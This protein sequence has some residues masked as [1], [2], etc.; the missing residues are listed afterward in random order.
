MDMNKNKNVDVGS[1]GLERIW[2]FNEK[3]KFIYF[4]ALVIFIL[5]SRFFTVN[6]IMFS[7]ANS[8]RY[9]ISALIQSEAAIFAIVITLSL[10]A[11]QQSASSYSPRVIEIFK[12]K[13]RNP[14]F[15]ILILIYVG[16]ILYGA[17][18]LK[19]IEG[20]DFPKSTLP[21]I[22]IQTHIWITYFLAFLA[23]FSLTRYVK[24]AFDLLNPSY[25]IKL[26]SENITRESL[27]SGNGI[28]IDTKKTNFK[29]KILTRIKIFR[30][31]KI[32]RK[33]IIEETIPA[34]TSP[35]LFDKDRDPILPIVDII[36]GS[37]MKYDYETTT[38]GIKTIEYNLINIMNSEPFFAESN[39]QLK[40]HDALEDQSYYDLIIINPMYRNV[41]EHL[42]NI[43]QLAVV[44]IDN[45]SSIEI[46]N[47]ITNII[48][49]I[50]KNKEINKFAQSIIV[51]GIFSLKNIGLTAS[52]Q[53]MDDVI[54][55]ILK[56]LRMIGDSAVT[57][58][59][60]YLALTA[61]E[62]ESYLKP[63][64]DEIWINLADFHFKFNSFDK[65][66]DAINKAIKIKSSSEAIYKKADIL[67]KLGDI[68]GSEKMLLEADLI[69]KKEM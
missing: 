49:T 45:R 1:A 31:M 36:R 4:P 54:I 13:N 62:V 7:D 11:V 37:L 68:E 53:K 26:L 64:C 41:F 66:Y 28:I 22:N 10:V 47:S 30:R 44:K 14:D 43:G 8:A 61:Y 3:L 33:I 27:I 15:W 59:R 25:I 69:S 63:E 19:I 38:T 58:N 50:F 23:F 9:M 20:N 65:A 32:V 5:I 60:E 18:V 56:S 39:E 16:S 21:F 55:K 6:Q 17:L 52:N 67:N 51:K 42:E 48:L 12:D 29:L 40:K 2:K 46:I 34:F 35:T 57:K 24:N